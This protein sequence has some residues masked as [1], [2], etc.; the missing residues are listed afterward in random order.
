[1]PSNETEN[2]EECIQTQKKESFKFHMLCISE[3]IT[4]KDNRAHVFIIYFSSNA[5]RYLEFFLNFY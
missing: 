5:V 2:R 4:R 1:M 3:R